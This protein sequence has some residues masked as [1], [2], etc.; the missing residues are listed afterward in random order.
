MDLLPSHTR[1][2]FAL[3]PIGS[4]ER[5]GDN[6]LVIV[7]FFFPAG[8][9]TFYATEGEPRDNDFL[10]FGYCISPLGADCDEW[11]YVTLSELRSVK[12][13]GLTMERDL[14]FPIAERTVAEAR[15]RAA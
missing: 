12:A 14:H 10:F 13:H 6:A 2:E 7:K 9:Y 1:A 5:R 8:R 4:Q 15:A 11:G 3:Y